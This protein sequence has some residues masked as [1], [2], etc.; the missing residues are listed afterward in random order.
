[1]IN[2]EVYR[3]GSEVA[4][5]AQGAAVTFQV[6][7]I[8]RASVALNRY[9]RTYRLEFPRPQWPGNAD[10]SRRPNAPDSAHRP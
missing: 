1:M 10:R 4:V 5:A 8:D 6:I 7:H 9:G 2:G 3:E